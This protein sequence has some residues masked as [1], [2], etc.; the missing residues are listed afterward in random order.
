MSA[1]VLSGVP[2][3]RTR[4]AASQYPIV[5]FSWD[6]T[7]EHDT[8][9]A[10]TDR[11]LPWA[12]AFMVGPYTGDDASIDTAIDYCMRYGLTPLIH[13][14]DLDLCGIEP[15]NPQLLAQL[16]AMVHRLGVEWVT[17]DLAMWVR[18]GQLLVDN[19]MAAPWVDGVVEHTIPRVRQIQ[20]ALGARVAIENS[21]HC[22]GVGH[23]NPF[24]IQAQIAAETDAY[25]CFDVGHTL[26]TAEVTGQDPDELM[27]ADFPWDL[28]VEGH[29][30]GV[31]SLAC[32]DG[33]TSDD[34]HRAPI[35]D[36]IWKLAGCTLAKAQNLVAWVA[37]SEGISAPDLSRKVA[38]MHAE[39]R[40]W[41]R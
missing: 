36:R 13:T 1:A 26:I 8:L 21:A 37:E 4:R 33:V 39:I 6:I 19:L 38:T 20:D 11:Y 32:A 27:P 30:A 40:R 23:L 25:L 12:E 3:A 17:A 31:T 35:A 18:R 7:T 29:V 15:L 28:V 34:Q 2:D 14:L 5:G 10:R 22:F 24:A 41:Q 16:A 9:A